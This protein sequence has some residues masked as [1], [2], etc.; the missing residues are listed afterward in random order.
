MKQIQHFVISLLELV[1]YYTMYVHLP[2]SNIGYFS[3]G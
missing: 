2:K 3:Y 1:K